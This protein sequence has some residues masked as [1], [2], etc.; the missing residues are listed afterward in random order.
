MKVYQINIINALI[1]I[2]LGLWGYWGSETPSPTAL[3]PVLGGALLLALFKGVKSGNKAVAHI[4]VILTLILLIGLLKP[5][6]GALGRSDNVAIVRVAVMIISCS[7]A[8]VYFVRSFINV[9]RARKKPG[10]SGVR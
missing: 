10:N 8:M 1:L 3:I 2:L 5:L 4:A 9:R 6:T 7:V